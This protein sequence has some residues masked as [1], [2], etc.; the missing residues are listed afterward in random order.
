MKSPES[1][2]ILENQAQVAEEF[3]D[4]WVMGSLGA[5]WLRCHPSPL[6]MHFFQTW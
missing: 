3:R 6:D 5:G 1:E 4:G 2:E